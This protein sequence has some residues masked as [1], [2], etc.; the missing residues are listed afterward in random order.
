MN[1]G[2]K[3]VIIW[4]TD[5]IKLMEGKPIGG[6]AVQMYFWAQT[7]VANKWKVFSFAKNAKSRVILDGIEFRPKKNIQ[8][9][10]FILEWWQAIKF[11]LILRPELLIFRGSSRQLLSLSLFARL[12]AVK[13]VLFG[14]SDSDFEINR[15][16]AGSTKLD[17][18]MYL[19]SIRRICYFV[20]QNQYQHNMLLSNF[21]KESLIQFNI[22]GHSKVDFEDCSPESDVVWVA[23]LRKLKRAEWV[24]EAAENLPDFR[25]VLAGGRT[26][27]AGYYDT[28][29]KQSEMLSNVVFLGGRS[30]FYVNDLVGKSHV[31]LCT[32]IYEGFPNTFLQ[33]WS[34]SIPVI[35]TVDPS[36]VIKT[37]HLG[38][39]VKSEEELRDALKLV[40]NDSNYYSFL[41]QSISTFFIKNHSAQIGYE[42]VI[43]YIYK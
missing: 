18:L 23:N 3:R 2:K 10:N 16:P 4:S 40:L 1:M 17:R 39:V 20:S 12:F 7:F 28:I 21:G 38:V 6:L 41:K 33:A 22:W 26:G 43:N 32:S 37:Y 5:I 19:R 25:F 9:I 8:R 29:Q 36:D 15:V 30:F 34:A 35:S 11:I 14:A 27:E 13:L 42:N 31:L 24:L